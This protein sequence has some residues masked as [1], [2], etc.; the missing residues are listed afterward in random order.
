MSADGR[1]SPNFLP[2]Y[3]PWQD[4]SLLVDIDTPAD[5]KKLEGLK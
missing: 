3:L 1:F 4:E 5:L 2:L